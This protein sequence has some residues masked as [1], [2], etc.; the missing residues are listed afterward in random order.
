MSRCTGST[1]YEAFS[2]LTNLYRIKVM[3][4]V[5][6]QK[7]RLLGWACFRLDRFPQGLRLLRLKGEDAKA[8]SAALLIESNLSYA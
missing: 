8:N 3:D 1:G 6:Y 4:D 5:S 7:D 2:M